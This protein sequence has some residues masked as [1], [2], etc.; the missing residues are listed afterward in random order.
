MLLKK[1]KQN[2]TYLY[3]NTHQKAIYGIK[4]RIVAALFQILNLILGSNT[5]VVLNE[6]TQ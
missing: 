5:F 6:E 3:M 1:K 4:I 2:K